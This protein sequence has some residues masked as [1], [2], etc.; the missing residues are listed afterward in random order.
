[1]ES[2]LDSSYIFNWNDLTY[3]NGLLLAEATDEMGF[4]Y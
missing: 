1:M 2:T 3:G 4:H